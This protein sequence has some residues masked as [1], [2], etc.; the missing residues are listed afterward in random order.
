MKSSNLS[1]TIISG[2]TTELCKTF[3]VEYPVLI[4]FLKVLEKA[5]IASQG[6]KQK[7]STGKGRKSIIW[8]IPEYFTMDLS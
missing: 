4:G 2:T 1:T 5:G 8:N 6:E 3:D 7:S